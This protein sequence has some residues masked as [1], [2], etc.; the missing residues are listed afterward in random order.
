MIRTRCD[1]CGRDFQPRNFIRHKLACLSRKRAAA[2][3]ATKAYRA[4]AA[5]SKVCR[6]C[7][8]TFGFRDEEAWNEPCPVDWCSHRE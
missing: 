2:R 1:V 6:K 5:K 8:R 4:M 3:K 7:G